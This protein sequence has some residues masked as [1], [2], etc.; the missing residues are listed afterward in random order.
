M[1]ETVY[2][3]YLPGQGH[4]DQAIGEIRCCSSNT[5]KLKLHDGQE[6]R[7]CS[8]YAAMKAVRLHYPS[9]YAEQA[10]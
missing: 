4:E 9:A 2:T 3:V 5:A 8:P 10:R 6:R 1:K 7:F